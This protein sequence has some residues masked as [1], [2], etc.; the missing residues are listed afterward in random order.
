MRK[1][2]NFMKIKSME[3]NKCSPP[4]SF[5]TDTAH[6]MSTCAGGDNQR[7]ATTAHYNTDQL[8]HSQIMQLVHHKLFQVLKHTYLHTHY[9]W[10]LNEVEIGMQ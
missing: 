10:V 9:V 8:V 2:H 3:K 7:L 1:V 5:G 6:P 4:L